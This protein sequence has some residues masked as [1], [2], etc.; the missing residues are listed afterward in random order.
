MSELAAPAQMTATGETGWVEIVAQRGSTELD[1]SWRNWK[2]AAE[3]IRRSGC[4]RMPSR[5][6]DFT[7]RGSSRNK[8]RMVGSTKGKLG[9]RQTIL[10]EQRDISR[11][12][13]ELGYREILCARP[14]IGSPLRC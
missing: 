13:R 10:H 14:E 5:S 2:G 12:P 9:D 8:V 11:D 1:F 6:P 4:E 3:A 7:R